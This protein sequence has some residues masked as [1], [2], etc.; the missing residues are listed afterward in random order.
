MKVHSKMKN[1]YIERVYQKCLAI[2][3]EKAA[4]SFKEEIDMPIFY[5]ETIVGR[6]RAYFI[7]ESKVVIELKSVTNLENE[8]IVQ[9]LNY[10]ETSGLE[11]CLLINF[12]SKSL[13]FKR[14]ISERKRV[15][16]NPTNHT[17]L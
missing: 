8:H 5:D 11:I 7:I 15:V 14:L 3:F 16:I 9:A 13:Q 4:L 10:L 1:G 17:N 12:G 6:R 2:E